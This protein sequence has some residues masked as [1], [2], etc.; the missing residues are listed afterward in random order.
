MR[1]LGH[2]QHAILA[3]AAR[4]SL[5]RVRPR[6]TLDRK[7]IRRLERRGILARVWGFPDL[8]EV[9]R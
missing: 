2:R 4:S 7:A 5:R 3:V 1:A 9:K 8:W 6:N